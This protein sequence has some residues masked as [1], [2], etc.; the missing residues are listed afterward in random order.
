MLENKARKYRLYNDLDSTQKMMT[1]MLKASAKFIKIQKEMARELDGKSLSR[2]EAG[3]AVCQD[4]S[5]RIENE[6]QTILLPYATTQK[7][8]I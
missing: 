3:E 7:G 2:T 6:Q 8:R 5:E 4:L 1:D